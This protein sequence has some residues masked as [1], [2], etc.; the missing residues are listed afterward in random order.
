MQFQE[1]VFYKGHYISYLILT[2]DKLS[3]HFSVKSRPGILEDIPDNF[4]VVYNAGKWIEDQ[5]LNED[6][7]TEIIKLIKK[8]R[9]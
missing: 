2:E 5:T 9:K 7:K 4:N 1:S 3:Y 8:I 6:Y